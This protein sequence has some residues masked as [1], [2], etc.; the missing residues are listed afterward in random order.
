MHDKN[1]YIW[2]KKIE[3]TS[4]LLL[5]KLQVFWIFFSSFVHLLER[6]P[7]A[8]S[9][10]RGNKL[11]ATQHLHLP[12]A[13]AVVTQK[14]F[15][16]CCFSRWFL[17]EFILILATLYYAEHNFLPFHH[18]HHCFDLFICGKREKNNGHTLENGS[19]WKLNHQQLSADVKMYAWVC[20]L[21][22]QQ[23]EGPNTKYDIKLTCKHKQTIESKYFVV[24]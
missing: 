19:T 15:L 12:T 2:R 24:K 7:F 14:L 3:W 1:V 10:V 16:F 11:N 5:K 18:H 4:K 13:T 9:K 21:F 22:H 8:R 23:K 17:F 20:K 6:F